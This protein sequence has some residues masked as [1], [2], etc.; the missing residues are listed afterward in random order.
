VTVWGSPGGSTPTNLRHMP[1]SPSVGGA[2]GGPDGPTEGVRAPSVGQGPGADR[3]DG[4]AGGDP[5]HGGAGGHQGPG[6]LALD[7]AGQVQEQ[8]VLVVAADDL[9]PDG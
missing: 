3:P 4:S 2:T 8:G 1:Q 5:S 7:D 9:H 6:S